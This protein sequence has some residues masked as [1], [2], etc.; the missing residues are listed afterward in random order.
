MHNPNSGQGLSTLVLALRT[1]CSVALV[2]SVCP[3]WDRQALL[4]LTDVDST[5]SSSR[6]SSV[7]NDLS[8]HI[9]TALELDENGPCG[10]WSSWWSPLFM[11]RLF[12]QGLPFLIC[13]MVVRVI[14]AVSRVHMAAF[15]R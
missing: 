11:A 2:K 15:Q 10:S 4:S 5:T 12:L 8:V 14:E 7:I 13:I 9:A 6:K 3:T 1:T